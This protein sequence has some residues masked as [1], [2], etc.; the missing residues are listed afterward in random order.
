MCLVFV[1]GLKQIVVYIL[2][3]YRTYS[4]TYG[5]YGTSL[6]KIKVKNKQLF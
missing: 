6:F 4:P 2:F 1:F 3:Q 5:T